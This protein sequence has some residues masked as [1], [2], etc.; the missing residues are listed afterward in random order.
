MQ[1]S[2]S[3]K[4]LKSRSYYE[5]TLGSSV[6]LAVSDDVF[7]AERLY[8]TYMYGGSIQYPELLEAHYISDGK[9]YDALFMPMTRDQW[10]KHLLDEEILDAFSV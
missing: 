1:F 2:T 6:V 8:Y 4:S 5:I 3:V 10:K 9:Q 7:T